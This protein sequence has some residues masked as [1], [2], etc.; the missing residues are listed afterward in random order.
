MMTRLLRLLRTLLIPAVLITLPM[1]VPLSAQLEPEG[2][3]VAYAYDY[4]PF[5]FTDDSGAAAGI[6][7]DIWKLWSEKT[8]IPVEFREA[9]WEEAM[10]MVGTGEADAHAGL[11]FSEERDRF[12]DYG[13]PLTKTETHYFSHRSLPPIPLPGD[14][15]SYR[16]GV[17]AGD[18]VEGYLQQ[19]L[20]PG[21]VV[22]YPD[23]GSLMDDLRQ[24]AL[25]VFASD[26]PIALHF[27][28]KHGLLLEFT[29]IHEKPLYRNDFFYAVREGNRLLID[30]IDRGMTMI[31]E[32][33][34]REIN[35]RW[36]VDIE[37]TGETLVIGI[38]RH[39]PPLSFINALGRPSGF[40]IDLWRQWSQQTGISVRFR[41]TEWSET[42]EGLRAGESD[43]HSGLSYSE[44][45]AEWIDFS[46]QIYETYS[47]IYYRI[48]EE[49]LPEIRDYS[50]GSLGVTFGT[51]QEAELRRD[52]P[53]VNVRSYS[54]TRDMI[55]ALLKGEIE[56]IVEEVQTMDTELDRLGL[57]G[58]IASQPGRLFVSSIHAGIL[59]GN[60]NL[61]GKINEGFDAIAPTRLTSLEKRWFPHLE[62]LYYEEAGAEVFLSDE[63]LA[64]LDAHPEIR[65]GT[66]VSWPPM[67]YLDENG[68]LT[69]ISVDYFR[70]VNRRLGGR[71][72]PEPAPF[73][74]NFERVKNRELDVVMDITP[75]SDREPYFIF[76]GSYLTI[77]HVIVGR[78]DGPYYR[79]EEDLAGKSVALEKGFYNIL[80]FRENH[81]DVSVMEY[82]S[83]SEALEA[84][85]RGEADAYAGN[86]AVLSHIIE[87]ELI[88][89]LRVMGRLDMPSVELSIGV[90][91]DWPE[92]ADIL[93][94]AL[95]SIPRE[96]VRRIYTRWL[97]EPEGPDI[98]VD[99]TEEE[100]LWLRQ[101]PVIRISAVP[102]WAPVSY[103]DRE[104]NPHGI[105]IDYLQRLGDL[106]N[107][108]FDIPPAQSWPDALSGVGA[109]ERDMFSSI[110]FTQERGKRFH[111]T[112][113]YLSIPVNIFAGADVTYIGDLD[114]L[115]GKTAAVLE[116]SAVQ[117]WLRKNHPEIDLVP[118]ESV[119]A[120]LGL[121]TG[122]EVYAFVGN[123]VTTS[124]YISKLRL[125]QIKVAGET[126]YQYDLAM[127]V[128]KDWLILAGILQKSLDALPRSEQD[129]IYNRWISVK[130]EH[131]FDYS[132]VWK[133][134]LPLLII[135]GFSILWIWLLKHQVSNRTADLRETSERLSLA[136]RAAGLGIWDWDV[137]SDELIWDD[138][139][140]DL[141]GITGKGVGNFRDIWF[142][143][144]HPEDRPRIE[145][146]V[147]KALTGGKDLNTEYRI[148]RSDGSGAYLESHACIYRDERDE[149]VRIIGLSRDI[150][151]RKLDELELEEHREHLEDLVKEQTARLRESH[152]KTASQNLA[153]DANAIL[154]H[155]TPRGIISYVNDRFC[156]MIQYERDELTGRN[157]NRFRSEYHDRAFWAGMW[158]A[159]RKGRV[160]REEIRN[161][162]KDGSWFWVDTV[163]A[164]ICDD[165][166][167]PTEY[168]SIG[169]DITDRKKLEK[170]LHK[171]RKE[172]ESA[173]RAK[174]DFLAN[175]SHE[176]RTPM[177]AIVGMNHLLGQTELTEKQ[178]DYL[179][180]MQSSSQILLGIITDIL[181]FSKIEA[182]KLE[183]ENIPFSLNDVLDNLIN[184]MGVKTDQAGLDLIIHLAGDVPVLLTGD[185][186]RLGQILLNLTNNAVK[187]TGNGEIELAVRMEKPPEILKAPD[188][189][190]TLHFSVRDT[191]I[192]MSPDQKARLFKPF[193][194]ADSST[195]RQYG[196]SGL[197]LSICMGLVEQM[198]GRIRAESDEGKGST[199][200]FQ[201]VF[202]RQ[203]PEKSLYLLPSEDLR[204]LPVMVIEGNPRVR[205]VLTEYL[206][207]F[208]FS[209]EAFGLDGTALRELRETAASETR[210]VVVMDWNLQGVD[211]FDIS[212]WMAG[213]GRTAPT[214]ITG[215]G[216][217]W[218][219]I[220]RQIR[221]PKSEYFLPKP[222]LQHSL[223]RRIM[224]LLG[225]KIPSDGPLRAAGFP[226]EAVPETIR[227]AGILLVEDNEIN[228]EVA[229]GLLENLG[230]RVV[231]AGN[232]VEAVGK[233]GSEEDFDAVLMD[234][235]M[236]G[237]DGYAAT[238]MI[239]QAGKD[240][241]IIAMTADAM[242]GVRERVLET[243]MNDYIT[244]PVEP[245]EL[246]AVLVRWIRPDRRKA[247]RMF[248]PDRDSGGRGYGLPALEGIR[249]E[250]GLARVG[251]NALLYRKLLVSFRKDDEQI[252][253]DIREALKSGNRPQAEHLTHSL[254]GVAGN[255]GADELGEAAR[256]LDRE[257]K[258]EGGGLEEAEKLL[259]NLEKAL[260]VVMASI[261]RL[262]ED[263]PPPEGS[264]RK[265]SPDR[266]EAETLLRELK[267]AL[268][269]SDPAAS[270]Y[271]LTLSEFLRDAGVDRELVRL[272][273]DLNRFEFDDALTALSALEAALRRQG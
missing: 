40:L 95:L 218:E 232:G 22:P 128:R 135:L 214:V 3:S 57:R 12:L 36:I 98:T 86:R 176:I 180:K 253:R 118:A 88:P 245:S 116:D 72:I 62:D 5:F 32:D 27:L 272:E 247:G 25:K 73:S 92:L 206:E 226:E 172:A 48:G 167:R 125:Y 255:L 269:E 238:R 147:R 64:W 87:K 76:T 241:P 96:E 152:E 110:A 67:S 173:T 170:E 216:S 161:Q 132:L 133:I 38:L 219:E 154:L 105:A 194:Q 211:G 56:G 251:G 155:T 231:I 196:G 34:K 191:G 142:E 227:G 80:Y 230:F 112:E 44:D 75:R 130:Y 260:A 240:L 11:F 54:T 97:G 160:W 138:R 143:R 190:V 53:D 202:D 115:R 197:G 52:Y 18:Y 162:A 127:A 46:D 266:E 178:Q 20:P 61:M 237:M 78:T 43:I 187:F 149:T 124:Y 163:I 1:P 257:L 136:G 150:T 114:A 267:A 244:K 175:M 14:L 59:K 181:D 182:G 153:L 158:Q 177:N 93:N 246:L 174:S 200:H 210:K 17:I 140:C 65:V 185:P 50:R 225:F 145:Q 39:Y 264:E 21:A 236:P 79:S 31:T 90:R 224:A 204:D 252:A 201:A 24:G 68:I 217:D 16:V 28:E 113:P 102:D 188:S 146:E 63:D 213:G 209:V 109:G 6:L 233:C 262:E 58:E 212:A 94:R 139:V 82:D 184:M 259:Q 29:H 159:V 179:K 270:G 242:S 248:R 30:V 8:A 15:A 119:P 117:E 183:L 84:V 103:F 45:R 186:L 192:G 205:T 221:D 141:F 85:S 104:G 91:K 165:S 49:P 243:G 249:T 120:A 107:V 121:M 234:L 171:A 156:Q 254:K 74:Q 101:N 207:G 123:V 144:L 10:N 35:Q 89:G 239:R 77:P 126:P 71:L 189:R 223:F 195:T 7:I 131:G 108:R 129:A 23:Y 122:G 164:P 99:L 193:S 51:Y 271:F 169:F 19:R 261:G 263:R 47:R 100:I 222:V 81:P 199:F 166:G 4:F 208:S 37:G 148:V 235:Q 66:M 26:T 168:I 198:G 265:E 134:G 69:G 151:K 83:T 157:I 229:R 220:S 70:L 55:N 228:Q 42:L 2:L 13:S 215:R 250:N 9:S 60:P 256:I 33:E 273:S 203:L 41:P 258:E 106:L 111:F 268:E 137:K